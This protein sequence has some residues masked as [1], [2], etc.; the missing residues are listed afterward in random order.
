METL[1]ALRRPI[2]EPLQ[3]AAPTVQELVQR[4]HDPQLEQLTVAQQEA[5]YFLVGAMITEKIETQCTKLNPKIDRLVKR[6]RGKW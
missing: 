1:N 3:K 6:I 4:Y 5:L 2:S